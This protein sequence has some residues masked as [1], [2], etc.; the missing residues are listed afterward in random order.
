VKI[1][2][3]SSWRNPYFEEVYEKISNWYFKNRHPEVYNFRD[4][5]SHFTWDQV[6]KNWESWGVD[7]FNKQLGHPAMIKGYE[8]DHKAL[9]H[10]DVL[11]LLLPC[12]NDA[13]L[14]A[15]FVSGQ[16]KP[17]IIFSP[18]GDGF[19]PGLMY[20]LSQRALV[21]TYQDLSAHLSIINH[22]NPT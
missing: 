4:P 10:C 7:E 17:V 5:R 13:H 11:V 16:S 2:L 22:R 20:K 9:L 18:N 3:A 8:R 15:G 6:D 12:G 19:T 1:Y 14:E 21:Q